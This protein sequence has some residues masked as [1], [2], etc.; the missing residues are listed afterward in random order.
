MKQ[1]EYRNRY[2]ANEG[3][4]IVR[5]LDD[6]IMGDTIDLGT[7]DTIQNYK[8]VEFSQEFIDNFKKKLEDPIDM[9]ADDIPDFL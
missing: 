8:D 9:P 6:F 3:C 2:K 7:Y 5:K 1:I 4:L